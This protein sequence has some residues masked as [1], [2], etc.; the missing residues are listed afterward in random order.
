MKIIERESWIIV[1][2]VLVLKLRRV[3]I[4]ENMF[5]LMVIYW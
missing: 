5:I 1:R 3:I 4:V 2:V